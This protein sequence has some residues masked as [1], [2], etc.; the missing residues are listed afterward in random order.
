MND[1]M[2]TTATMTDPGTSLP[3]PGPWQPLLEDRLDPGLAFRQF[4][5]RGPVLADLLAD[6]SDLGAEFRS[7]LV[8][9]GTDLGPQG[10]GHDEADGDKPAEH[11]HKRRPVEAL[12]GRSPNRLSQEL[13]LLPREAVACPF[14]RVGQRLSSFTLRPN[15]C[16]SPTFRKALALAVTLALASTAHA[17]T[18]PLG[19]VPGTPPDSLAGLRDCRAEAL[20]EAWDEMLPLQAEAVKAEVLALCTERVEAVATFLAGQARLDA[21][22]AELRASGASSGGSR[23]LSVPDAVP[24]LRAEISG[25]RDR[26]ARL[27]GQPERPETEA[28]LAGLRG[29]LA[30]A[31]AD[32]A[33]LEGGAA[34]GD[35]Q[36]VPADPAELEETGDVAAPSAPETLPPPGS[37]LLAAPGPDAQDPPLT[38]GSVTALAPPG[39]VMPGAS[40]AMAA[41]ASD[42]PRPGPTEWR[43]VFAVRQDGGPWLV[44]LQG[45]REIRLPVPVSGTGEAGSDAVIPSD[46]RWKSVTESDLPVDLSVGDL[47]PDG[48]ALLAV[49]PAGVEIGDPDDPDAEPVLVRFATAD[50]S[51]PGA[52]EWDFKVIEGEQE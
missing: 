36:V 11:R 48:T 7:E 41:E 30:S 13:D 35:P 33:R 15:L 31:Q 17:Q 45:S 4:R 43:A 47:L 29:E 32:L 34:S 49:T 20:Q 25:L 40:P 6:G 2:L 18:R 27:E 3:S 46:I 39:T 21:A 12:G 22:L 44:R 14:R 52:L 37:G 24:R 10:A 23:E 9:D 26:I 8:P 28:T 38:D 5:D 16:A 19:T 1:A 50:D 51:D 42:A